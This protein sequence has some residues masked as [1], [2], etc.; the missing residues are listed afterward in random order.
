VTA[1]RVWAPIAERVEVEIG[2]ERRPMIADAG[3]WW[4]A[5]VPAD[6]GAEYA[7]V[8]DGSSLLPDPRS[9]S[10]PRGVDGPSQIVDHDAFAWSDAGWQP[11]PL[12]DAVLYELHVGTFTPG[13]TFDSASERLDHLVELGVTHVEL[14]PV[15][16]FAGER[17]WGYDGV[18]LYA[19]HHAY[20]G[21]AGLKRFVDACH[22]R[23]LAA[24]LDVVYNHFGPAGNFL[25]R[26]GPYLTSRY[27]TPW[28]P[29]VNLDG[30]ESD[31]VR[32]FL[33]DN[34]RMWLRDYHF[35]GLRLDAV[36]AIH[37][38][39]ALHFLE[40]L[41]LEVADLEHELGRRL[42]LIA[43]SDLNDPAWCARE[44]SAGT[45]TRHS[46]ATTSTTPSTPS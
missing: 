39:S 26:F 44:R 20:G 46:G 18:D 15:Q 32:R 12:G 31:E 13:G 11:G 35:D 27:A 41:A 29:A 19:P 38:S 24:V 9:P 2:G 4:S 43:E 1:L 34:A 6:P 14:M 28:G 7:Y 17:G 45:A 5:A 30:A 3:G 33:C 10:Q 40:Q 42:V 37:D 25:P 36:H 21:P 22:R 8:V 23:G 16:E